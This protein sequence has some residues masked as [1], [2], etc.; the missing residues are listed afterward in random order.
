MAFCLIFSD[1]GT[2]AAYVWA[3]VTIT[4]PQ[5]TV[6]QELAERLLQQHPCLA[7]HACKNALFG[8]RLAG[9]LLPHAL[10]HLAIDLLV[11]AHPGQVFAGNTCWLEDKENTM[12]V[13]IS[14]PE[15]GSALP[16]HEALSE[17]LQLLN[18]LL[19]SSHDAPDKP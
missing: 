1:T 2:N 19:A 15:G 12:R 5:T 13:R 6:S 16:V 7:Q 14:L 8:D 11:A 4:G 18:T 9:A 3:D 10:E 17:A